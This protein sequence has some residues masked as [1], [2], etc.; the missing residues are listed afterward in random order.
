MSACTCLQCKLAY[1]LNVT[2]GLLHA[3]CQGVCL[4][5]TGFCG[6][7]AACI[8]RRKL[9]YCH[10]MHSPQQCFHCCR[11]LRPHQ[12]VGVQF[13]WE[14]TMGL[15]E[16]NRRGAILADDMGLGCELWQSVSP[17]Q[18]YAAWHRCRGAIP[19]ARWASGVHAL[20][21]VMLHVLFAA[22]CCARL[23]GHPSLCK[24]TLAAGTSMPIAFSSRHATRF[25][26]HAGRRCRCC[27]WCG[28][29]CGRD[30]QG[31]PLRPRCV[32][33]LHRLRNKVCGGRST[34]QSHSV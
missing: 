22:A 17:R 10:R 28:R 19:A 33:Q 9:P 1:T 21:T 8:C 11:H 6:M 14:C 26:K 34:E 25:C 29:R 5:K 24:S 16:A 7:A 3:N 13:L 32:S 30:R 20:G 27:R 23:S 31:G 12:R 4:I 15:R 18:C 2:L